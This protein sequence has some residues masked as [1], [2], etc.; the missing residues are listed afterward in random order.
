MRV[1]EPFNPYR[2][3]V[4]AQIPN[5]LLRYT[6]IPAS[7]KLVWARLAQYAGEKGVAWPSQ[8]TLAAEV[9]LSCRQLR[10]MLK[11]LEDSGFIKR[12]QPTGADRLAHETT[13]YVFLRHEVLKEEKLRQEVECRSDTEVDF[14]QRESVVRESVFK[15]STSS[16]EDA[17]NATPP[18]EQIQAYWNSK[19]RLGVYH[20]CH[21]LTPQRKRHLRARWK[22]LGFRENWQKIIDLCDESDFLVFNE[23]NF[24]SFTWW[25][26]NPENWAK[27]LDG[28]YRNKKR[29]IEDEIG[30]IFDRKRTVDDEPIT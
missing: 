9:G 1:G 12:L 24:F 7:A 23:R 28:Q 14:P 30:F 6:G 4:G 13:R 16:K 27:I 20:P 5:A 11:V 19:P 17:S 8:E 10:N 26:K 29:E 18:Y 22:E 21:Q 2:L 3:F 15:E 25:I